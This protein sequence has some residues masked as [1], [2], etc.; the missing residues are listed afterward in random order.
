MFQQSGSQQNDS[1]SLRDSFNIFYLLVS[2]Y[3]TCLTVFLRRGFGGEALG[4]NAMIAVVIMGIYM[5]FNP[6]SGGM[7]DLFWLWWIALICHRIGYFIRRQR[8]FVVHSQYHGSSWFA[9]LPYGLDTFMEV[10]LCIF[11]GGLLAGHDQPLGRFIFFGAFALMAK[12]WIE[13]SMV[14]RQ[15][16]RMQDAA[17]EQGFRLDQ[18]RGGKY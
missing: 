11:L 9:F 17:I 18:W 6:R 8:G 3:A 14:R 4:F 13:G 15:V 1:L 2:G 16:M 12:H 10:G 7:L 5:A